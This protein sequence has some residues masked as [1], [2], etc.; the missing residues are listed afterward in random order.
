MKCFNFSVLSPHFKANCIYRS[1]HS[2]TNTCLKNCVFQQYILYSCFFFVLYNFLSLDIAHFFVFS[3]YLEF[4]LHC[5]IGFFRDLILSKN[6]KKTNSLLIFVHYCYYYS[7][8]LSC[9]HCLH[10]FFSKPGSVSH[11]LQYH[12]PFSSCPSCSHGLRLIFTAPARPPLQ[13]VLIQISGVFSVSNMTQTFWVSVP[14]QKN[15]DNGTAPAPGFPEKLRLRRTCT[16]G[17]TETLGPV[18]G[19]SRPWGFV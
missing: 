14:D 15:M 13:Q 8:S 18:L 1:W 7:G 2:F 10:Y 6:N 12:I 5:T 16:T 9:A 4:I 11:F 19:P 3:D 17:L